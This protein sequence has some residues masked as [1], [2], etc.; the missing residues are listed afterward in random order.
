LLTTL[1]EQPNARA[2]LDL[3]QLLL[4]APANEELSSW[5]ASV[6]FGGQWRRLRPSAP[7]VEANLNAEPNA[8]RQSKQ[9]LHGP[10]GP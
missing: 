5:G 4:P 10:R 6:T 3:Y 9:I 8:P 1:D 7:E 2:S